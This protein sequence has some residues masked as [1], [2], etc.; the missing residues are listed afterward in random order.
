MTPET[1]SFEGHDCVRLH[2]GGV[3]VMVTTSVG[4]RVLGLAGGD[5]NVMAVL[6]GA[7]LERADG[8]RFSFIGGHRLWAAPEIPEVTYQPDDRPCA[9]TEVDGGIRVEA[10]TDGAGL[11][12]TLS[13]R[14]SHGGW[15][16]DHEIGNASGRAVTVATW[17]ITQLRPGGTATLPLP[18]RGPGPQADRALVLWPYTD[19]ADPR[20][21]VE[22]GAVSIRS[23]PGG[24]PLKLG[25]APGDGALAYRVGGEVFEK[26]VDIDPE[27]AYADRGAALQVY[28]CDAFCELETLGPLRAL[29]PGE[30]VTHRE[31]WTL[32]GVDV[33]RSDT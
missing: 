15:T 2:D 25:V 30:T 6:P 19:L 23:A 33:G 14:R 24:P 4:P 16:V 29:E 32:R 20:V 1:L 3:T 8:G 28:L 13:V 26:R 31:R 7:G 11:T 18:S 22:R 27:A 5:G 10:P 9:A 17:A 21:Q 12:K